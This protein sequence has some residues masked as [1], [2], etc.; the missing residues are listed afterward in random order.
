MKILLINAVY[1][2]LS[3]GRS[4]REFHD[5]AINQGHECLTVYGGHYNR[6]Y[7][8]TIYLGSNISHKIHAISARIAGEAGIGSW[9]ATRNLLKI[10]KNY[11]PDVVHLR[12][13]HGNFVHIP[14]LLK[15]LAENNIPTVVNLDDC[16]WFTG[17]CMHYTANHCF[18]WRSNC[19][20]CQHLKRGDNYIF[21]NNA[22]E[23][24]ARKIEL[25]SSIRRLAV[26]GVSKWIA[27]EASESPV[28]SKAKIIDY[29]YN[30]IDLKLFSP[31]NQ[32]RNMMTRDNLGIAP[33]STLVVGVA[34]GWG[35]NKGLDDFKV[36]RN[37]LSDDV[38]ICLVG[39]MAKGTCLP[40]GIINIPAT[41]NAS[42]L[43]D[44]YSAADVFV[45]LSREETFGKVTAEALACGTS[46]V[47][48]NSTASPELVDMSTGVIVEPG[49]I[50]GVA[51]AIEKLMHSDNTNACRKRAEHLF[52][53]ETN[54]NRLIDFYQQV[55]N[56]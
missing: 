19:S 39:H 35:A 29:V 16:Y 27:H 34:S 28:F 51:L 8:D 48:Y 47:V 22:S 33:N 18:A 5:F 46:A 44:I 40:K 21:K 36:L 49:N 6:E 38:I 20:Q 24:L 25:F 31:R 3:T 50:K 15:F 12:N 42:S 37:A 56:I 7:P 45:H 26:L 13:L 41:N 2:I 53:L 14:H 30:W 11:Q 17:G 43:A 10:I 55:I 32:S 1:G 54:C 23:N 52:S 9:Q 4:C